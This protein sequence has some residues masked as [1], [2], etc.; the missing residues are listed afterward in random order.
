MSEIPTRNDQEGEFDT[1]VQEVFSSLPGPIQDFLTGPERDA[2]T[3]RI[4]NAHNLHADQAGAFQKAFIFMLMGI[5][6]PEEFVS[7]LIEAGIPELTVR[8]LA[9]DV[10]EM[11]FKPLREKERKVNTETT[12]TVDS[13]PPKSITPPATYTAHIAPAE[14]MPAPYAGARPQPLTP[15]NLPGTDA[16]PDDLFRTSTR[17]VASVQAANP[18]PQPSSP[19]VNKVSAPPQPIVPPQAPQPT[20]AQMPVEKV[21]TPV[22]PAQTTR[23]E[24]LGGT[25]RTMATDMLAVNEHREPE[26]V[27]YKGTVFTPPILM[28]KIPEMVPVA[29]KPQSPLPPAPQITNAPPAIRPVVRPTVTSS[30]SSDLIKEY[31]SDPYREP[32]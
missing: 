29:P 1:N 23:E 20:P 2:V 15:F 22:Q 6:S 9:N 13:R 10:N 27:Q 30:P 14:K 16:H 19:P 8:A 4:S 11:V 21:F 32:V 25:L 3:I 5:S 17:T 24:S 28:E 12:D 31:S 18:V 7:E 26:P